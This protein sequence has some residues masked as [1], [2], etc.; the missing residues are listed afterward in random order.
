MFY[1]FNESSMY[2]NGFK[3]INTQ[4]T[5]KTKGLCLTS[6]F[7][8]TKDNVLGHPLM[9]SPVQWGGVGGL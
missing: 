3:K 7:N 4:I 9:Y 5:L 6:S 1:I 2:Q 8:Q